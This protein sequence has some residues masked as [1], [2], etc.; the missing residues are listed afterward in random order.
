MSTSSYD[1]LY[2]DGEN[3]YFMSNETFDQVSLNK[4]ALD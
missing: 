1:Y 2:N 3:Y 4:E